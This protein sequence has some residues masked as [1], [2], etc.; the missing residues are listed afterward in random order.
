MNLYKINTYQAKNSR[1]AAAEG[2]LIVER[3]PIDALYDQGKAFAIF[4]KRDDDFDVRFQTKD[5][6]K[7]IPSVVAVMG[8]HCDVK[9]EM[10]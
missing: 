6:R 8:L 2:D 10:V 7:W 5:I 9:N 3:C 4:I 1:A